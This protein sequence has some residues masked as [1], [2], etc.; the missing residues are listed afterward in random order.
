M[1]QNVLMGRPAKALHGRCEHPVEMLL[2]GLVD[3]TQFKLRLTQERKLGGIFTVPCRKCPQCLASRRNLWSQRAKQESLLASRTWFCTF[4]FGS[5]IRTKMLWQARRRASQ[6]GEDFDTFEPSEKYRYLDPIAG[7]YLTLYLKRVRKNSGARL[8][9][10]A[11]SEPHGDGMPHYHA[12]VHEV[13][14]TITKRQL[15]DAWPH[16]F[17]LCKLSDEKAAYYVAK[18]LAKYS[19]ARVRASTR[20]GAFDGAAALRIDGTLREMVDKLR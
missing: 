13:E 7:S 6:S 1:A 2:V 10:M 12:L 15:Q 9:Y 4:T 8:R 20:Y 17:S 18:Y 14:G 19:N 5:D 11:V 16:G 3:E